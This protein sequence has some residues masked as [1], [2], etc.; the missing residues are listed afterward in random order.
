[1]NET[2]FSNR[3]AERF[4]L[5]G[6]V[7]FFLALADIVAGLMPSLYYGSLIGA[8][9]SVAGFVIL[10]GA[11]M[12]I[13]GIGLSQM[14]EPSESVFPEELERETTS[15]APPPKETP[16]FLGEPYQPPKPADTNI[17]PEP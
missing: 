7:L 13:G 8:L 16:E 4:R 1:M 17:P 12:W 10:F 11:A 9:A 5:I 2:R 15:T 14:E 6:F 3:R